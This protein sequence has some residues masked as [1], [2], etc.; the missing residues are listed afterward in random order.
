MTSIFYTDW[1]SHATFRSDTKR[2]SG[3]L[4]GVLWADTVADLGR[5]SATFAVPAAPPEIWYHSAMQ[6][7]IPLLASPRM[8]V[9]MS[10]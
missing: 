7:R 5:V 2:E 4:R 3:A 9:T 8:L 10:G 1:I 6:A